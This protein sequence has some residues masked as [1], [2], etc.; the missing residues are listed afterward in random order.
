MFLTTLCC[1]EFFWFCFYI[2]LSSSSSSYNESF[3]FPPR[4]LLS[5]TL[6]LLFYTMQGKERWTAIKC[7]CL[8]DHNPQ[9]CTHDPKK[10]N[11]PFIPFFNL[12]N[13]VQP[14][15]WWARD[16][17]VMSGLNY[18]R[19]YGTWKAAFKEHH[20]IILVEGLCPDFITPLL[21]WVF[22]SNQ[23][24]RDFMLSSLHV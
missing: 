3:G 8:Q 24:P 18:F 21:F 23:L 5:V 13:P 14:W 15:K 4:F 22:S 11:A 2:N 6:E 19:L 10:L 1:L 12:K 20:F 17:K 9:I 7:N 16:S